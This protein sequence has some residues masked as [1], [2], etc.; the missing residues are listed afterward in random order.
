[1]QSGWVSSLI[2]ILYPLWAYQWSDHECGCCLG[3]FRDK[4]VYTRSQCYLDAE[5][6]QPV[7]RTG[8]VVVYRV[9]SEMGKIWRVS[10][11]ASVTSLWP[12]K[13]FVQPGFMSGLSNVFLKQSFLWKEH[14]CWC[15]LCRWMINMQYPQWLLMEVFPNWHHCKGQCCSPAIDW[16][17]P[18]GQAWTSPADWTGH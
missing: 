4:T 15:S 12:R 10:S 9:S 17:V 8:G 7:Y 14:Q 18:G 16:W 13:L 3:C 5:V 2:E 1:M 11:G 6:K